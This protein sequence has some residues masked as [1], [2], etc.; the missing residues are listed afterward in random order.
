MFVFLYCGAT[1]QVNSILSVIDGTESA[2]RSF[3]KRLSSL[4][5]R[6]YVVVSDCWLLV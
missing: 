6:A 3:T 5:D 1:V 2:L 4:N